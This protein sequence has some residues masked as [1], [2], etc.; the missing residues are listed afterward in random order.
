MLAPSSHAG[1]WFWVG[2]IIADSTDADT[3][4]SVGLNEICDFCK[5]KI[6][7]SVMLHLRMV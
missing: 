2:S 4:I 5:L 1:I 7:V 6:A 3:W